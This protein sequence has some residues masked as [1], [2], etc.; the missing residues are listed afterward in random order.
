MLK[1]KL[2]DFINNKWTVEYLKNEGSKE[3]E[4]GVNRFN[5]PAQK[6]YK[7]VGFRVKSVYDEG[8]ILHIKL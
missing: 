7:S 1:A 6:L 4:I 8:M 3:L 5:I 2:I